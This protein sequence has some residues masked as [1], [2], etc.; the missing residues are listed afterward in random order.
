[1][2]GVRRVARSILKWFSALYVVAIIVQVFLA[3]EGIFGLNNIKHADDC[4][5]NAALCVGNSD[6]LDAHRA[7]GFFL[8]M[9]GALLFLIV[10]LLAW[11]AGQ[12]R[13]DRLDRRPVPHVP[14]DHPRGRRPS[15]WSV[16]PAERDSRAL[17][18]R[19][20]RGDAVSRLGRRSGHGAG[21]GDLSE[22]RSCVTAPGRSDH[23]VAQERVA[24][25]PVVDDLL[26][27]HGWVALRDV[28]RAARIDRPRQGRER[29]PVGVPGLVRR[30][31]RR[32]R[33]ARSRATPTAEAKRCVEDQDI[34]AGVDLD[35]DRPGAGHL[36]R[37]N[38]SALNSSC[39]TRTSTLAPSRAR[40]ASDAS[41]SST[42]C[43]CG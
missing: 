17:P 38:T 39:S 14:P 32:A 15:G 28:R 3:G 13:T 41:S 34:A 33:P 42:I 23:E 29:P 27:H 35:V 4:D 5:K 21:G 6:T 40:A 18:L 10:A 36:E 1:M 16:P 30:R 31:R 43:R 37:R 2:S 11:F 19:L 7:L 22:P 26:E 20:A 9:P 12:A 8:T 24:D 25:E